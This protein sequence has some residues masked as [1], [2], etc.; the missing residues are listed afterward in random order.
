MCGVSGLIKREPL[1]PGDR[2][3]V[4]AASALQINRG[5]DGEGSHDDQ[6]VS[7]RI[8]RLS[9]IDLESGWQPLR[10]EDKTVALIAN[11][12]IY[13]YVELREKLQGL[14]HQF[15]T[16]SDCET[17]VHLY[18]EY[19]DDCVDHLRGMFAFALHDLRRQRILCARDRMGEKPFYL[20]E[21]DGLVAFASE[22][23]G[24]MAMGLV[25]FELDPAAIDLYMHYDWV[26]EPGTPIRGIRKLP[27]GHTLAI[28]LAP[29]S[30]RQ[31]RYWSM[32]DVTPIYGDPVE[33]IRAEL[34]TVV[35]LTLRSDVPVGIALSGG[36]DSSAI[37][38]LAAR[39]NHRVVQ[40]FTVGYEGRARQDERGIARRLAADLG[41]PFHELEIGAGDVVDSFDELNRVRDEPI[42]DIAGQ[43][44]WAVARA[45]REHGCPVML[46]GQGADELFWGYSWV[47]RAVAA[48]EAKSCGAY[49]QHVAR[50]GARALLPERLTPAAMREYIRHLGAMA[51]GWRPLLPSRPTPPGQLVL[52]DT[53][54]GYQAAEH[55]APLIYTPRLREELASSATRPA[56]C[57]T[58]ARP[59]GNLDVLV[60]QI[61]CDT[62]LLQNGLCQGDRLFMASSV[63]LRIPFVDYRL[64]ETVIGLRKAGTDVHL[65]PKAW[66]KAAI[67]DVVPDWILRR[68]KVGFSP[69]AWAWMEKLREAFGPSLADGY[70]VENGFLLRS[71]AIEMARPHSR[72]TGWGSTLFKTLVLESWCRSMA[73]M[74]A[75]N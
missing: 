29:W 45:A 1:S 71:A 56:D 17:I 21:R 52:W 18:E 39:K 51:T 41:M 23:R 7:M 34:E 40:A 14:G 5:P 6:H 35:E 50:T 28:E 73:A 65:A 10:N 38:C 58:F 26:P 2:A 11:G 46:Q 48:S 54:E 66:F 70:L 30:V 68:P 69:P 74:G 4:A 43:G 36:I 33:A 24:L 72:L 62:Y 8:R 61:I 15:A 67:R 49:Q 55:A 42:A 59:W 22:L 63:E 20:V 12:E 16:G 31:R 47:S 57:F 64:V 53:T 25:P 75:T 9:I 37:A 27:A 44:Y 60:T 13:N 3:R 19:G 32:A